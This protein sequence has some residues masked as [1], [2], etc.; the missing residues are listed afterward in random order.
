MQ[1][2][3]LSNSPERH[4]KRVMR[5][6]EVMDLVALSKSSLYSLAAQGKFPKSIPLVPGGSSRA[7]IFSEVQQWL[8]ERIADRDLEVGN[9]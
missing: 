7:W 4:G 6:R 5:I 2:D 9:E 8:D 1:R 3:Q